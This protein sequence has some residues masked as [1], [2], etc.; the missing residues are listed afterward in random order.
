MAH[1]ASPNLSSPWFQIGYTHLCKLLQ[2]EDSIKQIRVEAPS[3]KDK[4]DRDVVHRPALSISVG[5]DD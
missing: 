5:G 4:V 1:S 2:S 3:A